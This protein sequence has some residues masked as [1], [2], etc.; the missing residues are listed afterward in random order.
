MIPLFL[1]KILHTLKNS[2]ICTKGIKI[3]FIKL[4]TF[5]SKAE[6]YSQSVI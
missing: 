2:K 1:L 6:A 5:A 3:D 4:V